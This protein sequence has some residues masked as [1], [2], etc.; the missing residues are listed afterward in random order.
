M[1]KPSLRSPSGSLIMTK[2]PRSVKIWTQD[3]VCRKTINRDC[4]VQSV[5]WLPQGEGKLTDRG[6]GK[7]IDESGSH[8]QHSYLS[9]RTRSFV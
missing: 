9:R 5:T 8:D 2:L 6:P 3:G 1:S 7:Q 4:Q